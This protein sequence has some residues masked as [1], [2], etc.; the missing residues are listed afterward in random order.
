MSTL[1]P[2]PAAP[3]G[4]GQGQDPAIASGPPKALFILGGLHVFLLVVSGL[5]ALVL[6]PLVS[7]LSPDL[8]R[9]VFIVLSL[10]L[11]VLGLAGFAIAVA[12]LILSIMSI[13][14]LPKG[15]PR[16]GA[17]LLLVSVLIAL[18]GVTFQVSG[19]AVPDA[20]LTTV[21]VLSGLADLLAIGLGVA[22]LVL[23]RS[24]SRSG[25]T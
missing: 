13:T 24:R 3:Q 17:I 2:P 23:L 10:V 12:T 15:R 25:R 5:A 11:G 18:G 22:G 8:A 6:G 14:R 19:N 7:A 9:T 16:T 4:Q 21:A 20:V 1:P